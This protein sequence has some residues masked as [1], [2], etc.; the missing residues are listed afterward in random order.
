MKKRLL[1]SWEGDGVDLVKTAKRLIK[2]QVIKWN[3]PIQG[4]RKESQIRLNVHRAVWSGLQI[5]SHGVK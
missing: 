5:L 3:R 2:S 4:T 1:I